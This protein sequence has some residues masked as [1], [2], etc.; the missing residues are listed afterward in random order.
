MVK[1]IGQSTKESYRNDIETS[2]KAKTVHKLYEY[3]DDHT[4]CKSDKMGFY[5]KQEDDDYYLYLFQNDG[6]RDENILKKFLEWRQSGNISNELGHKGGGNKRNIYGHHCDE[7][8]IFMKIDDKFVIICGT[9]PND[10]YKLSISD[11]DEETFRSESDSS[12]YIT[13]P[14]KKKIRDLPSWYEKIFYELEEKFKIIPNFIIRLNLTK[15]PEDY[16]DKNTWNELINNIRAKQ[17]KIPIIF[18]NELLNRKVILNISEA[19]KANNNYVDFE[20]KN[21]IDLVGFY[22]K[23]KSKE[24][25][26]NLY[27]SHET[28]QFYLKNSKDLINIKTQKKEE[29]KPELI[30]WGSVKMY[31][32]DNKYVINE[33]KK[34]NEGIINSRKLEDFYGIYLLLN[35]K[36]TNYLP[37]EG[38]ILGESKNN[39]IMENGKSTNKFRMIIMPSNEI[40][41][42][43]LNLLINTNDIKA[44]TN[45]L[46]NSPY[47][48]LKTELIKIYR[49]MNRSNK[50]PNKPEPLKKNPGG[51]YIIYLG[52]GLFKYGM[53]TDFCNL[54]K[55][56]EKHKNDSIN[57]I[58]EF[59]NDFQG[60]ELP[61][62]KR[63]DIIFEIKTEKPKSG[64][65]II[66]NILET[67]KRDKIT[68]IQNKKS[69]NETREYFIC[70]DFDYIR[71]TIYE[72]VLEKFQN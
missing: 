1:V 7:V 43:S 10:L 3:F 17:Y 67:H 47:N 40:D 59:I 6:P 63:I 5:L 61:K 33:L 23:N 56:Y 15:I 57:K 37:F 35:G 13:N 4:Y 46:N 53:V 19:D 62:I 30:I 50:P 8:N 12:T 18:I 32:M 65:E 44:L 58:N 72:L 2:R 38:K 69:K 24:I 71:T 52:N 27:Y 29:Y 20:K 25:N 68:M 28:E 49:F 34:Y 14:V 16:N 21:N 26:I 51:N 64:E 66:E 45:F 54:K 36:F 9:R 48:N 22:D 39:K 55:R 60:K 31:I 41:N 11:I 42:N 70:N